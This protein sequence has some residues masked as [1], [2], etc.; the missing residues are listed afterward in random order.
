MKKSTK[1]LAILLVVLLLTGVMS[2]CSNSNPTQPS[3]DANPQTVSIGKDIKNEAITIAWLPLSTQ[4]PTNISTMAGA[5]AVRRVYPNVTLKVYDC[6]FDLTTQISMVNECITQKVDAILL[7]ALDA[8][9]LNQVITDAETAGIPVITVGLA[10]TA[11]YTLATIGVDYEGGQMVAETLARQLNNQGNVV[12][13]DAPA[14]QESGINTYEGLRDYFE[15]NTPGIEIIDY[16]NVPNWSTEN[17]NQIAR[18]LLT[19]HDKIDAI[20]CAAD[21]LAVGALQACQALG[22]TDILIW[23]TSPGLPLVLEN[24]RDGLIA[25]TIAYDAVL[26][27]EISM[28]MALN[29]IQLG[30][31]AVALGFEKT[32]TLNITM[33]PVTIENVEKILARVG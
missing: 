28:Y 23:G 16:Q 5:D 29:S 13:L 14:E 6:G 25:G 15:Q 18:D 33:E 24:I 20:W 26:E 19:K 8:T 7:Q 21:E 1:V 17:A 31:N 11:V 9:A 22:Y 32:P 12:A 3:T 30:T 27:M 4:G 10:A 2:G